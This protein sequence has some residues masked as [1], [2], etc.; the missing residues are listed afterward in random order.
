MSNDKKHSRQKAHR[1]CAVDSPQNLAWKFVNSP[2]RQIAN[3]LREHRWALSDTGT[4]RRMGTR[5]QESAE[6]GG[7]TG[8][9]RKQ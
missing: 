4:G 9:R 8:G 2:A 6:M 1:L 7:Q 3:W 5:K